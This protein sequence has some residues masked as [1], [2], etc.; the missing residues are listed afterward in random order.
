MKLE[1]AEAM[2]YALMK[3]HGL[4]TQDPATV[5][6]RRTDGEFIRYGWAFEWMQKRYKFRRAGQCVW[7]KALI[8]LQPR[9]VECN[10]PFIVKR[11]IL[12]EIAHA[13]VGAR[14][15]HNRVWKEMA[16]RIGDD[17][18]ARYGKEVKKRLPKK[19]KQ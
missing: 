8:M 5:G 13:L 6:M 12:H 1:D 11:T 10:Y 4:Y 9:F 7:S 15:G 16:I 18:G 3:H 2:A 17:G 19:I 14:N